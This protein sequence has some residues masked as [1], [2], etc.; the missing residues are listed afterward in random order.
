MRP[1]DIQLC[2]HPRYQRRGRN[3]WETRPKEPTEQRRE[4]HAQA[5]MLCQSCPL[6]EAC[7]AA[8]SDLEVQGLGVDGVMAGRMSDV[9]G[10]GVVEKQDRCR[11]CGLRLQPQKRVA[12]KRRLLP[13][14]RPHVGEGLCD[15][16]YPEHHRQARLTRQKEAS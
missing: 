5:R 8:L 12:E 16:C 13:G 7:E 2:R 1:Y 6:L 9:P 10:Y 14:Q 4:R 11:V 3:L 15:R